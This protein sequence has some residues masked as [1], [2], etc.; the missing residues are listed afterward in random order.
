MAEK[1]EGVAANIVE[2]NA[3]VLCRLFRQS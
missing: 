2:V 3:R 1:A